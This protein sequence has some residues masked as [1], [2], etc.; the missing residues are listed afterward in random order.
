MATPSRAGTLSFCTHG[1]EGGTDDITLYSAVYTTFKC[2]QPLPLHPHFKTCLHSIPYN[3]ADS[4]PFYNHWTLFHT[5][6]TPFHHMA[7]FH[8]S[9]WSHSMLY[10]WV[11]PIYTNVCDPFPYTPHASFYTT[12]QCGSIPYHTV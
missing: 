6:V 8:T 9:V 2:M 4:I 7:S 3:T 11:L 5:V 10:Q 1:M 12:V